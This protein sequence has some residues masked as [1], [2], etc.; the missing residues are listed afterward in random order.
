MMHSE[1]DDLGD[2]LKPGKA[3]VT[4]SGRM[5]KKPQVKDFVEPNF[6]DEDE[7]E[8]FEEEEE[9]E[10]SEYGIDKKDDDFHVDSEEDYDSDCLN[11]DLAKKSLMKQGFDDISKNSVSINGRKE[12]THKQVDI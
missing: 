8:E 6:D 1:N 9:E 4:F 5:A 11:Y 12:E 3:V 10:D 2:G 7:E